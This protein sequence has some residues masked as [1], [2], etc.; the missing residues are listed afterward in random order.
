MPQSSMKAFA[1][2][3][4]FEWSLGDRDIV[5]DVWP[6]FVVKRDM[7]RVLEATCAT[8]NNELQF[9]FDQRLG[10]DT[11]DWREID[12]L[13][14]IQLVAGMMPCLLRP[15]V[16]TLAGIQAWP[17]KMSQWMVPLWKKRLEALQVDREDPTHNEP[18]DL[19]QM[20]IRYA[21]TE[22]P[23][24]LDNYTGITARMASLNFGTVHRTA[25]QAS[26]LFLD[27]IASDTESL[28]VAVL[29]ADS[30][31]HKTLRL[32]SFGNQSTFRKIMA[33][34][35]KTP[36]GTHI[37]Q[38]TPISSFS[39]PGYTDVSTA[40]DPDKFA[41]FRFSRL[42]EQAGDKG[43]PLGLV[44]TSQE[45]L[46]FSHGNYACPGRFLIDLELKMVLTHVLRNY[47]LEFPEEYNGQRPP[48]TW[49][50]GAVF[51]PKGVKIMV[52][53]REIKFSK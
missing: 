32:N 7:N 18:L 29:R 44:S 1:D 14:T 6:G 37:P 10:L 46:T 27:V 20:V 53:R 49:L 33:G 19:T 24:G 3:D 42:R 17:T 12:L 11:E 16:G 45:F 38:G 47:N 30:V 31:G 34:D 28:I 51:S 8:M 52:K 15:I 50:A 25:M 35:F 41:P 36:D 43:L 26:N 4:Q 39:Q 2:I 5:L 48:N 9:A 23:R 13:P 22:R 21:H 40:E